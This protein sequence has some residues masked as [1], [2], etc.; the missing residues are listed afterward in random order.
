MRMSSRVVAAPATYEDLLQ[1]PDTMVAELIDGELYA[2]PRPAGPHTKA[3][4]VLGMIIGSAF[5]LGTTGPGGWWILDEPELHLAA[6][7]VF[8]PDLAGWRCERMPHEPD[9]H[10]FTV[11]PD[12]V[13]EVLSRST[14]RVDR[15]K[16]MPIYAR[17][18]VAYAWIVD[19]EQQFLE[20]KRLV[21]GVWTDIASFA[22]DVRVRAEPF[23]EIEVPM[24]L[25]WGAAPS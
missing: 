25:V 21:D 23:G 8:V 9:D 12:W 17:N 4:S 5:H 11:V 10:R 16:K 2:W 18:G 13:C 14:E 24:T 3:A 20:V 19:V 7:D 6:G 1:V 15:V 22:G